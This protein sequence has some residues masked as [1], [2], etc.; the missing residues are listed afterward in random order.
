MG[1]D[2]LRRR[3]CCAIRLDCAV[4]LFDESL[5]VSVRT[6][7]QCPE[8]IRIGMTQLQYLQREGPGGRAAPQPAGQS[9]PGSSFAAGDCL[10]R[11]R[12]TRAPNPDPPLRGPSLGCEGRREST[13]V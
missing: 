11:A 10:V 3:R 6:G 5:R 13:M 8:P 9:A 12:P 2:L 1:P 7:R 4:R